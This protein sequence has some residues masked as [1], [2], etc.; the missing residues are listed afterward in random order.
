MVVGAIGELDMK[1][2]RWQVEPLGGGIGCF[3]MVL[4]SV[5]ASIVL[6]VLLNVLIR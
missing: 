3:T 1:L 5:V 2:G 6:T 4:L